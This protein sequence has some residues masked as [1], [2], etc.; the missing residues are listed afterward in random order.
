MT[1]IKCTCEGIGCGRVVANAK[2]IRIPGLHKRLCSICRNRERNRLNK[3]R[4]NDCKPQI[5]DS[6]SKSLEKQK[7]LCRPSKFIKNNISSDEEEVLKQKYGFDKF[8]VG[9]NKCK[10]VSNVKNQLRKTRIFK[11]NER[12]NECKKIEEDEKNKAEK[13]EKFL[14]G[15]ITK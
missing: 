2:L 3:D 15:L 7:K 1:R 14:D 12:L 6:M 13:N 11:S 5:N 10:E 9:S 8:R 4:I